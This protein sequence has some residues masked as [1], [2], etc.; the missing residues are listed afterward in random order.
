[1]G[2]KEYAVVEKHGQESLSRSL[3]SIQGLV[4]NWKLYSVLGYLEI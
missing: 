4:E 2:G 1:M 3:I